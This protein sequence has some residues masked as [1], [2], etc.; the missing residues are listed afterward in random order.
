M[1]SHRRGDVDVPSTDTSPFDN[2]S[3]KLGR[4][5]YFVRIV[6]THDD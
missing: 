1:I 3:R 5:V 6:L 2:F 4:L